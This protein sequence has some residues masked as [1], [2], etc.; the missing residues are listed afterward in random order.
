MK[1]YELTEEWINVYNS[2]DDPDMDDESWFGMMEAIE[3]DIE[4][5]AENTAKIITQLNAEAEAYKKEADR[6][7]DRAKARKNRADWLKKNIENT[8][9]ATGKTKF[10]TDLFSFNIQKNAP[11]LKLDDVDIED[12]P[13]EYV[14]YPSPEINKAVV[15]EALKNGT[16]LEWARLEQGESLRIR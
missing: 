6:L 4:F 9:I 13:A 12:I 5:K 15:K 10:K 3:G 16:E 7:A 1:L 2:A 14:F 11:A 8:M